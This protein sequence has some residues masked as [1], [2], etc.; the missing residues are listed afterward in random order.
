MD[1]EDAKKIWGE[2]WVHDIALIDET[3]R[4]PGL[5]M[6]SRI[7]DIGTGQGIMAI[8]LALNG[9]SVLTGEPETGSEER[10]H[11]EKEMEGFNHNHEYEGFNFTDWK[12][13]A[14][15]AGVG[16]KIEFKHFNAEQLPFLDESFDGVFL[17]DALQHIRDRKRALSESI[18]VA[19]YNGV[20][21]VVETNEHG[22]KHFCETEGFEIEKVD[23]RD[24]I[25]DDSV[26]VEVI[27]GK[28]ANAYILRKS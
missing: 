8:S 22:I 7:L 19:G 10:R 26:T 9:Y 20:V 15:A 14:K 18:R 24:L 3:I 6:D 23:P 16:N 17:Y 2:E 4:Q 1:L 13:A 27:I 28:Y 21:C 5:S 11:Y 25:A 12:E